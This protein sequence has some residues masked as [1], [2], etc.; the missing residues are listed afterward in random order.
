MS[1][2]LNF[3]GVSAI[4][5]AAIAAIALGATSPN[6]IAQASPTPEATQD[7]SDQGRTSFHFA[8]FTVR[9]IKAWEPEVADVLLVSE[10]AHPVARLTGSDRGG[11][12]P[13]ALTL[14]FAYSATTWVSV[15]GNESLWTRPESTDLAQPQASEMVE[16]AV[17]KPGANLPEIYGQRPPVRRELENSPELYLDPGP[18]PLQF[19]TT[20]EEVEIQGTQP[21]TLQ[22]VLDLARRNNRDLQVA[23]LRLEQAK[24]QLREALAAEYPTLTAQGDI[25]RSQSA[26]GQIAE[27]NQPQPNRNQDAPTTTLTGTLALNYD[28]YTSGF[29]SANIRVG[30]KQVRLSELEIERLQEEVRL[31]V[32][33][34]YYDLQQSD[35]QVRIREQAVR[36]AESSLRD[37]QA[38]ERAGVGT[39]FSVLQS[40]VQLAEE[41]QRLTEATSQQRL[42]RRILVEQLSL[43]QFI[44]ISA[45][46]PVE[47]A[48]TWNIPLDQSI[49]LAF[50]NRVELETQLVTRELN[51]QQRLARL[52]T[53]GPQIRLFANYNVFELNSDDNLSTQQGSGDG[54]SFGARVTWNLFDGGQAKAQAAQEEAETAIAETTFADQRNEIRLQVERSYFNLISSF[55]NIGTASVALEQAK[56]AL[57]LARLRFQAGVGTQTDVINSETDLTQAEFNRVQAVLGYNRALA[58]LQRAISNISASESP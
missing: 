28:I 58:N 18:N 3:I 16:V 41:E 48:G 57:R 20:P 56:E 17:Q 26:Q 37:A 38:L 32:T 33:E 51:Q 29:R 31:A 7:A 27:V 49:I 4:F 10:S 23:Q 54:Y 8:P 42:S 11:S 44:D 6:T 34:S 30:K 55:D 1:K 50:Q 14:S 21:L 36:N 47:I 39:R 45:A 24:A 15:S 52:A 22:Q 35:E 9:S 2:K 40:Q 5:R 43:P 13:R 53:L 12:F 19:P 46:D 25:T